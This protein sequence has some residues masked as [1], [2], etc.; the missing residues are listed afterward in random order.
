MPS[1]QS[2]TQFTPGV[3]ELSCSIAL[4]FTGFPKQKRNC[5][6]LS[7]DGHLAGPRVGIEVGKPWKELSLP[8]GQGEVRDVHTWLLFL[9]ID[10]EK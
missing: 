3:F 2:F 10:G 1:N 5:W 7:P 4:K 9:C 8:E 6:M